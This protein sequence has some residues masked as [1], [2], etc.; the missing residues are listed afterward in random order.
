MAN[1]TFN[2]CITDT[3]NGNPDFS[4]FF[5]TPNPFKPSYAPK[6]T[7]CFK[8]CLKFVIEKCKIEENMEP[9]Y[10]EENFSGFNIIKIDYDMDFH[11]NI[12]YITKNENDITQDIKEQMYE[13]LIEY[14]DS[15][16]NDHKNIIDRF[17]KFKKNT[18]LNNIIRQKKL[19]NINK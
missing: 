2:S 4:V 13:K 12:I 17:E 1:P 5:G 14:I 11:K 10:V 18:I 15:S 6:Q 3:T 9:Y 8:F 16:I 7:E 19:N